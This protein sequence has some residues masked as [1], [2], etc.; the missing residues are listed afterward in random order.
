MSAKT[1]IVVLHMKQLILFGSLTIFAALLVILFISF[2]KNKPHSTPDT[3]ETMAYV[4]GIYTSS[5]KLSNSIVEVQVTVD[6]N[7]INSIEFVNMDDA[8]ETMY[9]LITPAFN[10][11]ATQILDKQSIEDITYSPDN[12]Y[13][14]LVLYQAI[15]SAIKKASLE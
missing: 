10:E 3:A 11:I 4:P 6:E 5:V 13:T 1:K 15:V 8:I 14:S 7:H 2:S 9:P 12:Q